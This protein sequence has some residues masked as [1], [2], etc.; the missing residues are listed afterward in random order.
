MKVNCWTEHSSLYYADNHACS[1]Y[2][3]TACANDSLDRS[4]SRVSKGPRADNCHGP[5]LALI[6]HCAPYLTNVTVTYA[7]STANQKNC[8]IRSSTSR[9]TAY[10]SCYALQENCLSMIV[11][12]LPTNC[13]T[14][15]QRLT[16]SKTLLLKM[17]MKIVYS[18]WQQ[19]MLDSHNYNKIQTQIRQ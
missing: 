13:R 8:S 17:K 3:C 12:D 5:R 9:N 19:C 15:L 16:D 4:L 1:M 14:C 2:P 10:I 11:S 6:R 7:T 18:V